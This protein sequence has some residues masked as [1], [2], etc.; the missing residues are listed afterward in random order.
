MFIYF[1]VLVLPIHCNVQCLHGEVVWGL[2]KGTLKI[3]CL[4]QPTIQVTEP[5]A[6]T[7]EGVAPELLALDLKDVSPPKSSSATVRTSSSTSS[8]SGISTS[9]PLL[10][11]VPKPR[12]SPLELKLPPL[13]VPPVVPPATLAEAV[14]L[15]RKSNMMLYLTLKHS[16]SELEY[17]PYSFK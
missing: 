7:S 2:Y 6:P 17:N 1:F 5:R 11:R 13:V 10:E 15:V 9:L 14:E 3:I 12:P 4:V 16:P 8:T